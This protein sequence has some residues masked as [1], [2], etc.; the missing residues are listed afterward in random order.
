MEIV[1]RVHEILSEKSVTDGRTGGLA[2]EG[3]FYN[4]HPLRGGGFINP[5]IC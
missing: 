5:M 2:D 4:P 1:Q 3:H